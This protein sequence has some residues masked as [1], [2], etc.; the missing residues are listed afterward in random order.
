MVARCQLKRIEGIDG[1]QVR[2]EYTGLS[3]TDTRRR[4]HGTGAL[5][6]GEISLL[7]SSICQR[8]LPMRTPL[9]AYES[10]GYSVWDSA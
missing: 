5:T 4:L 9:D 2:P 7:L 1:R 3:A 8:D 6:F 10:P